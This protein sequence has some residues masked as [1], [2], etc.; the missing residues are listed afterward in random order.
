MN[1]I[2]NG[3]Y[4]KWTLLFGS[5]LILDTSRMVQSDSSFNWGTSGLG[6]PG[7]SSS[8]YS[9]ADSDPSSDSSSSKAP[10]GPSDGGSSGGDSGSATGAGSSG[11]SASAWSS[12]GFGPSGGCREQSSQPGQRGSVRWDRDYAHSASASASASGSNNQVN[13]RDD[14]ITVRRIRNNRRGFDS[15]W[16]NE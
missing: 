14:E 11:H 12:G 13:D 4:K 3:Y 16:A 2:K 5:L 7:G 10:P 6:Y 1:T 9:G 8:G 15:V